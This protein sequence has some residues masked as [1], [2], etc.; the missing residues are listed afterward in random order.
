[1]LNHFEQVLCPVISLWNYRAPFMDVKNPLHQN[2]GFMVLPGKALK[3]RIRNFCPFQNIT[4]LLQL[5]HSAK[6]S[7][8]RQIL[9]KPQPP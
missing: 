9:I 3:I 8:S 6:A 4:P 1:M 2:Y 7:L 5:L